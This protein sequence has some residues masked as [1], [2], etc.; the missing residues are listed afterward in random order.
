[1]PIPKISLKVDDRFYYGW[2]MLMCSFMAMF[3]CY[4]IKVNCHGLFINSLCKEFDITRTVYAQTN[5]LLTLSMLISSSFMG[6]LYKK[7]SVKYAMTACVLITSCCY[8]GMSYATAFW[9]ILLLSAIQGIGWAGAT[10]LPVSIMVSNW[11][12][13]KVKGTAMSIGML[14]SAAGA[15]VWVPFINGL[16]A[17]SGWRTGYLG[18]AGVNA[19][20]IPLVLIFAV[21][22]PADKGFEIR[23]GDPS[24]E[25][26]KAAGGISTQKT[27]LTGSQALKTARWWCQWLAHFLTMI[28]A[29]AFSFQFVAYFAQEG[30]LGD[31]TAATA[32][33]KN[34]LGTLILGKFI[35]GTVS[36]VIHIKRSSVIAPLF[37]AGVFFCMAIAPDNMKMAMIAIPALYFIGGA[38]PSVI[39]FLITARNF[40]DKEYGVMS[41]WMNMAGNA[42]QILGPTIAAFIFD[43]TGSY[44]MFWSFSAVLL[45]VVSILYFLSGRVSL[46]KIR[47]WGFDPK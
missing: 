47:A 11:F 40:G 13:P 24:P 20:M 25:E 29:A 27:G 23:I 36:D 18:M 42:G 12:G 19:I 38:V 14:G 7:F 8:L 45:I 35:L 3:I 2:V 28:G 1:M 43:T 15:L 41:G 37:Y 46:E 4:V 10:T 9:Q 32:L 5:T 34:T 44:G 21:T 17:S 16:I 6:R 39:P 22:M 30:L 31:Q 33:Y 26:I